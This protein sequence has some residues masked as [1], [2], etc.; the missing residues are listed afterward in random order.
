MVQRGL[1]SFKPTEVILTHE[2]KSLE[3]PSEADNRL[4]S[5]DV[6]VV[7]GLPVPMGYD[8]VHNSV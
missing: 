4:R 5:K 2:Q 6:I 8:S 1:S 7:T 3:T